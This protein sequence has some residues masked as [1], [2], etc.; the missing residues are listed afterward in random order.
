MA[1]R[2]LI[3][4]TDT[5]AVNVNSSLTLSY[6]VAYTISKIAV[7]WKHVPLVI[8][9]GIYAK[10]YRLSLTT[11]ATAVLLALSFDAV[12]DSLIGPLSSP[13]Y[14]HHYEGSFQLFHF[15]LSDFP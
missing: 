7:A 9:Q 4:R 13:G 2:V 8:I 3:P 12:T 14:T 11:I 6:C 15:T 5:R 1:I 10:Y